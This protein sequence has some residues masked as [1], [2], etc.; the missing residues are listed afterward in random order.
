MGIK[1]EADTDTDLTGIDLQDVQGNG[2]DL[3]AAFGLRQRCAL[4][5]HLTH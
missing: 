4:G 2:M 3:D 1:M 5:E